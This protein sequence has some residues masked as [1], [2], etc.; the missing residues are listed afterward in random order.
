LGSRHTAQA[1]SAACQ[2]ERFRDALIAI[3][4]DAF[5]VSTLMPRAAPAAE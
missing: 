3:D 2:V 4:T 1:P 5:N